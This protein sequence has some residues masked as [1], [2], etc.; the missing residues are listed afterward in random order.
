MQKVMIGF[1][2]SPEEKKAIDDRAKERM[3][4]ASEV[5]R[6][7]AMLWAQLEPVA[8]DHIRRLANAAGVPLHVVVQ[9]LAI[10]D[11]AKKAAE[12]EMHGEAMGPLLPGIWAADYGKPSVKTGR[13]LFEKL[14]DE[15]IRRIKI[16]LMQKDI[17]G[18][19][20][21]DHK[22]LRELQ[23]AAEEGEE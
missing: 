9:N 4:S 7:G 17:Y 13:E 12:S 5:M 16:D 11:M 3:T 6:E 21:E 15:Q 20:K 1:K 22:I 18:W 19:L 2:A 23:K 10:G 8:E 14:K